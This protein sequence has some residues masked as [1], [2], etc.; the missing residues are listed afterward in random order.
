MTS[1]PGFKQWKVEM[2]ISLTEYIMCDRNK[3]QNRN[4]ECVKE[5]TKNIKC[6]VE[7]R[8]RI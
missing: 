4:G 8:F 2:N 3:I 1:M 7:L 6:V 5:T